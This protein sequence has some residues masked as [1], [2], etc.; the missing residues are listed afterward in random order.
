[1]NKQLS[2]L[3]TTLGIV[4]KD[5]HLIQ[6]AFVHRSYLNESKEFEMSNERLEYLGDAVL[7]LATSH[8]LYMT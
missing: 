4:V 2:D 1:M 7:E 8:F 3:L 6:N 5:E